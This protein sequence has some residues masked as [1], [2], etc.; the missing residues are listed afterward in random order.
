MNFFFGYD[1]NSSL[2]EYES[3]AHEFSF[4]VNQGRGCQISIP[5]SLKDR[6][7][8]ESL[9]FWKSSVQA[10]LKSSSLKVYKFS[11]IYIINK[12]FQAGQLPTQASDDL[13]YQIMDRYAELGGNFLDTA[14]VYGFGKSEEIVGNWLSKYA[15]IIWATS[16]ENVPSNMHKMRRFRVSCACA[17]YHPGIC[18]PFKYSVVVNV[19]GQ[20]SL[21]SDC[22]C[23]KSILSLLCP[24]MTRR[25]IFAW[26]SRKHAYIILTPLNPTFI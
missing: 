24:H 18:V 23:A 6:M 20:W 3:L 25:H 8:L 2:D 9:V 13:S 5:F 21:W 4:I 15:N 22:A 26:S 11:F 17:K 12:Y 10:P 19:S 14:N 1:Q 16:S 7:H